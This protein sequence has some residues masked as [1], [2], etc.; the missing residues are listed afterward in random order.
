[1]R[2]CCKLAQ[3]YKTKNDWMEEMIL[4]ELSKRLKFDHTIKKYT[5]E[6]KSVLE[7]ET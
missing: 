5:H 6:L 4:W 7:N 3:E 1:M 2:E